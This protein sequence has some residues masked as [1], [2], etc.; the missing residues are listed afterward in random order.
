MRPWRFR[1]RTVLS[2]LILDDMVA[3]KRWVFAMPN[4]AGRAEPTGTG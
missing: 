1:V 2:Q 4:A 3:S